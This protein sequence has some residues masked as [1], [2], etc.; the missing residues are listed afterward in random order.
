MPLSKTLIREIRSL[1]K[2]EGRKSRHRFLVEGPKMV[3]ELLK[4]NW[5]LREIFATEAW[6]GWSAGNTLSGDPAVY[7][8]SE[9]ELSRIST[10]VT[11]NQVLAVADIPPVTLD[12]KLLS[13]DLTLA[14]DGISDP[15]NLGTILR[16]ADWFGIRQVLC[17][18]GSVDVFSPKTVQAS[19]G[20]VFRVNVLVEDLKSFLSDLPP[21]LPVY[22]SF[23][24]GPP[25]HQTKLQQ[26]GLLLIGSESHGISAG[27]I[28]LISHKVSI[29]AFAH[30]GQTGRAESLN[31]AF[32]TAILCHEF[33][34]RGTVEN[35]HC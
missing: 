3:A 31:A 4:S 29:S 20:S 24:E 8:V 14:L 27:L 34:T 1:H 6:P 28:P 30:P 11:P 26:K 9:A 32:A 12:W 7:A 15:G 10:L 22:G 2:A 21:D 18:R 19:M 13:G 17:S 25:L 35:L 5:P 33:R 23:P 16:I